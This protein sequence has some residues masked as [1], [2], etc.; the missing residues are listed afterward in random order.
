MIRRLRGIGIAVSN[1]LVL[2]RS[3]ANESHDSQ[4]L[5]CAHSDI[6]AMDAGYGSEFASQD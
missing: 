6:L 2:F 3:F 4:T 1:H 5:G